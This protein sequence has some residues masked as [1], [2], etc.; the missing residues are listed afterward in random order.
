P[1]LD[2]FHPDARSTQ[3]P[4][5]TATGTLLSTPIR[6]HLGALRIRA[7]VGILGRADTG[8]SALISQLAG[9]TTTAVQDSSTRKARRGCVDVHITGARIALVDTPPVLGQS[10]GLKWRRHPGVPLRLAARAHDLQI[11]LFMLQ[12]CDTLLVVCDVDRDC[13]V[14]WALARLLASARGLVAEIPGLVLP[15]RGGSASGD[16]G[17]CRLHIL[18]RCAT[19]GACAAGVAAQYEAATGICV[20]RVTFLPGAGDLPSGGLDA[21]A[22]DAAAAWAALPARPLYAAPGPQSHPAP[23]SVL[24]ALGSLNA[25]QRPTNKLNACIDELRQCVLAPAAPDLWRNEPEGVWA[26][27]CLRAW[28]SIRRS[29]KLH[30]LAAAAAATRDP[31]LDSMDSATTT[32]SE[33][34]GNRPRNRPKR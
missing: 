31:D 12:V 29:D 1:A 8:K 18:A 7:C 34:K 3:Q 4:I 27:T 5:I 9:P 20:A 23:L 22:L 21:T 14:D 33:R 6:Q 26:S 11:A 32:T 19:G 28:D 2:L 10:A 30:A 24:P 15:A 25:Q 16:P 17:R 13:V